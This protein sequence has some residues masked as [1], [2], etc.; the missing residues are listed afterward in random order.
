M[1]SGHKLQCTTVL[2][3]P[4]LYSSHSEKMSSNNFVLMGQEKKNWMTIENKQT[5]NSKK[6]WKSW[7]IYPD[8]RNPWENYIVKDLHIG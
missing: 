6:M 3:I 8:K 7:Q 1:V 4:S 5:K 2:F